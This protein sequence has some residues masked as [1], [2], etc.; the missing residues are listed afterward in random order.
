MIVKLSTD[1]DGFFYKGNG[2]TLVICNDGN[3][4]LFYI[5][6]QD[7]GKLFLTSVS[8]KILISLNADSC[9]PD[10]IICENAE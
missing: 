4:P 6:L 3:N 10:S 2:E 9:A 5:D 7:G 1:K 8:D